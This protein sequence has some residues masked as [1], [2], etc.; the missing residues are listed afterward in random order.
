MAIFVTYQQYREC[1]NKPDLIPCALP[2]E[3]A[4]KI[5]NKIRRDLNL[6]VIGITGSIGKTTTKDFI[7][8]VVKGSFNS[9]K[10]IGNENTQYPI[11]HNMQRMSKNTE[12]FVQEFGMGSPGTISYALDACNPDIG[13]ITNIKEAHIHDYGTAENILKEKEKMV[14]K[15]SVGSIVVLNYDDDTL[16][17]WDWNK[18]KTIWVSLKNKKDVYKRQ[19]L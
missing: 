3:I 13:V 12:V 7:Y 18:Y 6:K 14:K 19:V 11:F 10:S 2:G 5:S 15:M 1:E 4:R 17:N 8:T 16:R 9:S